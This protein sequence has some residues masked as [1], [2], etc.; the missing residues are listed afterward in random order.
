[1]HPTIDKYLTGYAEPE[2]RALSL[3]N[4]PV[5][6][7]LCVV[8]IYDEPLAGLLAL[9]NHPS[10]KPIGM[11][12]VF[13]CPDNADDRACL[14]T[15]AVLATLALRF[16][17]NA[18]SDDV[19]VAQISSTLTLYVLDFC[20][21]GKLL[22]AKQGVGLARKL[23]L[24]LALKLAREVYQCYGEEISWLHSCDAD[25]ILPPDYFKIPKPAASIVACLYPF[26]HMP[27]PGY[28]LSMH[29]Y[30]FSLRYYVDRLRWAGSPYAF[31]TI[32]S[33]IAVTPLGYAQVRG[34]P[35][36]S[37]AEDF[38]LLNKLAKV[39]EVAS[40]E[41]PL[42]QI[43]GRPSHR[44]PFGTGPALQKMQAMVD[45]I[46]EFTVYHP[47]IFRAL[48]ALLQTVEQSD[49]RYFTLE[50]FY[51]QLFSGVEP[52]MIKAVLATLQSLKLEQAFRHWHRHA[53]QAQF[54]TSF[55]TWFDAFVT[56][57]FVHLM[58]AQGYP[59]VT[60]SELTLVTGPLSD[61]LQEQLSVIAVHQG[62]Q[63][64]SLHSRRQEV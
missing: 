58:R 10:S 45:P 25:V 2:V 15:R 41:Q 60:L 33:T 19:K 42:L 57:R 52:S 14:R 51:Q 29:L 28:E 6:R 13:N 49:S 55:H 20:A 59:S 30:D 22:P 1:M 39:G 53:D 11:I 63:A 24:D 43:A 44:V 27:V 31:H 48:R 32:G 56:L 37:G 12:W 23:G 50:E 62:I 8:P 3:S 35:K 40:L 34:M 61:E 54:T 18:L 38:Y 36:R 47:E 7:A 46:G 17:F 26:R 5:L 64:Y 16:C 4:P 9:L 21:P